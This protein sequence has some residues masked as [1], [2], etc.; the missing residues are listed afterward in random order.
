MNLSGSAFRRSCKLLLSSVPARA[1][2]ENL[3]LYI[4]ES[5]G[6]Q[7]P[8]NWHNLCRDSIQSNYLCELLLKESGEVGVTTELSWLP[9]QLPEIVK[10]V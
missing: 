4:E 1:S 5:I 10:I 2:A 7:C 9:N 6:I 8:L 3:Q